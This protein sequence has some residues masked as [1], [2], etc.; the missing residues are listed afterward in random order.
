MQVTDILGDAGAPEAI[1]PGDTATGITETIRVQEIHG[2]TK[3][4][5]GALLTCEDETVN[6]TFDGTA[7]T[8]LAGTN[9]GHAFS[10]GESYVVRGTH[11]VKNFQCIDRVSTATG[12][13]K[14]TPF[15]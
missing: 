6:I 5:I 14:V 15:F 1:A 2:A 8:A 7:P 4:A 3:E 11:N 12:T 9:V 13:V 10:A